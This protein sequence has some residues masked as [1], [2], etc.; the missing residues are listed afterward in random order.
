MI[1]MSKP[2]A[3]QIYVKGK[4]LNVTMNIYMIQNIY[5]AIIQL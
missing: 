4:I 3:L 1:D 5:K 2:I